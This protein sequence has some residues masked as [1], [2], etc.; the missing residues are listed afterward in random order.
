MIRLTG[1]KKSPVQRIQKKIDKSLTKMIE[2]N[3][4]KINVNNPHNIKIGKQKSLLNII[5]EN[6]AQNQIHRIGQ[7][8]QKSKCHKFY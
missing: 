1:H 3:H 6:I 2:H 8:P 5:S 4:K 7:K